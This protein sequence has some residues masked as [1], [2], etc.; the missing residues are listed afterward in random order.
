[1]HLV[2]FGSVAGLAL[3]RIRRTLLTDG[4]RLGSSGVDIRCE[5]NGRQTVERGMRRMFVLTSAAVTLGGTATMPAHAS[6]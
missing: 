3:D 4:S 2:H 5:M 1:M 6:A